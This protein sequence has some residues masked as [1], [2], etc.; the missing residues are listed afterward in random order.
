MDRQRRQETSG[1]EMNEDTSD[2][3]MKLELKDMKKYV[4]ETAHT[5]DPK[6]GNKIGKKVEL[7]KG[8]NH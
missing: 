1:A 3:R 4:P 8:G 5:L 7:T 2:P 6:T